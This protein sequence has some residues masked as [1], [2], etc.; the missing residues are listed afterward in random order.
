MVETPCSMQAIISVTGAPSQASMLTSHRWGQQF[1]L[2]ESCYGAGTGAS[3]A[4]VTKALHVHIA[5]MGPNISYVSSPMLLHCTQAWTIWLHVHLCFF[6]DAVPGEEEGSEPSK[7]G[8]IQM[9][10]N[11]QHS[12]SR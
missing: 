8:A 10:S 4:T 7:V 11:H 1:I 3:A 12:G 2:A 6:K 5:G 9:A